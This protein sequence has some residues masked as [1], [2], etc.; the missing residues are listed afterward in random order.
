M[1]AVLKAGASLTTG[2]SRLLRAASAVAAPP[3]APQPPGRWLTESELQ[4]RLAESFDRGVREGCQQAEQRI[5]ESARAEA[6]AA[7]RQ[8]LQQAL[9]DHQSEAGR[10]LA[11]RWHSVAASLADQMKALR[12]AVE[13]EVTEWT[14]IATTRLLGEVSA[15][16]L[17]SSVRRVLDD[18][19]LR[20]PAQVLVHIDDHAVICTES[21]TWPPEV[22]FMPDP[23]VGLGGCL[24]RTPWQ[25]LDA[26]LEVQLEFLRQALDGARRARLRIGG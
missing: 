11:A 15:E 12:E 7:A 14:F 13:S 23:A 19:G 10:A 17:R 26:R 1:N 4:A 3:Q 2:S 8:A 5:R 6:E 22:Q 9:T 16:Q 24:V 18:A 20:E 21:T 25:T